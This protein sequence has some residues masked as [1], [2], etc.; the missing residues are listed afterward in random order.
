MRVTQQLVSSSDVCGSH[1]GEQSD[2]RLL[3]RDVMQIY[4]QVH[5]VSMSRQLL[6]SQRN[7]EN[8][9]LN[10]EERGYRETSAPI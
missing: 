10:I 5:A 7:C 8:S 4:Q 3:K 9:T 2:Y 6:H 1:D